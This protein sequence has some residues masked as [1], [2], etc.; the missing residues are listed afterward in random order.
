MLTRLLF[1][2]GE[3]T[4][5]GMDVPAFLGKEMALRRLPKVCVYRAAAASLIS[6]QRGGV[7]LPHQMRLQHGR[8]LKVDVV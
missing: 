2:Q 4:A 5:T 3:A 7:A 6:Q 1:V 8:D